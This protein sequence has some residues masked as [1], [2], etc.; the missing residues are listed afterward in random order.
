MRDIDILRA[1]L[2]DP[3]LNWLGF[4]YG[5]L[6]GATLGYMAAK[7]GDP[8]GS[9]FYNPG[10]PG[11]SGIESIPGGQWDAARSTGLSAGQAMIYVVLPQAVH[12]VLPDLVSNTVEVVKLT[13]IASAAL[14]R[15]GPIAAATSA[16]YTWPESP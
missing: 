8:I 15:P 12:N 4:S 7:G 11:A 13:S 1:A 3:K 2:G 6:L 9:L 10:G 16:P 14:A 5:T